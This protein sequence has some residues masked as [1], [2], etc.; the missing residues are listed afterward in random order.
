MFE[1]GSI[2]NQL[3]VE[4]LNYFIYV[5]LLLIGLWA[6]I[7]KNNLI[8]KL[9][10]M[11]IFQTAIILFYVSIGVKEGAT[12][13]IYL[14]EH[15]PH[16]SHAQLDSNQ[17]DLL[18][19]G[20]KV[21]EASAVPNYTNPLPHVLMLTAIVV[22]V[23]TLG[24]ALSVC[25]RIYRG[26]GT[27]EEDELLEKL[28][29]EDSRKAGGSNKRRPRR[30]T[31]ANKGGTAGQSKRGQTTEKTKSDKPTPRRR[32]ASKSRTKTNGPAKEQPKSSNKENDKTKPV[33]RRRP[34]KKPKEDES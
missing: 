17:T 32:Q 23:A 26:Y 18:S 24:L 30:R 8:K 27:V 10:G 31:P 3:L 5:V 19:H 16:G 11:S 21:L 6:M 33:K 28:E 9:I 22:G 4:R 12:I 2:F 20:A 1:D 13:P 34:A 15:D 29:R 14:P 7:A 25:L